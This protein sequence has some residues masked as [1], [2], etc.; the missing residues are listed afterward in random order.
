M[1]KAKEVIRRMPAARE[2]RKTPVQ[3][4]LF[5]ASKLELPEIMYQHTVFCQVGFP[6]RDPGPHQ[7]DWHHRDGNVSLIVSALP[8]VHP[9]TQEL[10]RPGLPFGS[11]ARLFLADIHNYAICK[12]DPVVDLEKSL[13]AYVQRLGLHRSGRDIRAVKEAIA[14][15][16]AALIQI[17]MPHMGARERFKTTLIESETS[18]DTETFQLW[19]RSN[20]RILWPLKAKLSHRYFEILLEHGVPL[21][22][23][24]YYALSHSAMAMDIY[25][26]LAQRLHRLK[27]ELELPWPIV[28]NHFG[29]NYERLRKFR[30][31]FRW[32]LN[33]VLKLYGAARVVPGKR[34]LKLRPSP[35][36]VL[37]SQILVP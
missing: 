7:T 23:E 9:V 32:A 21:R 14:R 35:P 5:E 30:E 2:I 27:S 3:Q 15:V 6:Y 18:P 36:P 1:E 29:Q 37:K 11:K 24:H 33:D 4:R 13:S 17:D 22:E 10:V 8:V 20:Q 25:A 31:K 26:W 28:Q 19:C 12:Q 16:C 34:G